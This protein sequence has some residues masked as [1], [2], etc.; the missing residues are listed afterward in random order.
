LEFEEVNANEEYKLC[1]EGEAK[2]VVVESIK[3]R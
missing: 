2:V 3:L 1:E